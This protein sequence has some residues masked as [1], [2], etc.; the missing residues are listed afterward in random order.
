MRVVEHPLSLKSAL[1]ALGAPSWRVAAAVL[2]VRSFAWGVP[3]RPL[4]KNI[5]QTISEIVYLTEICCQPTTDQVIATP[6]G[7]IGNLDE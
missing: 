6:V 2:M 3:E 1:G 5:R 4:R 7:D